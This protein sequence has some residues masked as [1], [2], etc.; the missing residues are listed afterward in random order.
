VAVVVARRGPDGPFGPGEVVEDRSLAAGRP[1]ATQADG[2]Q[3]PGLGVLPSGGLTAVLADVA[4]N[5]E[6]GEVRVSA[7]PAG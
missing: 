4:A 1:L 6:G 7:R 5:A 3:P 2:L